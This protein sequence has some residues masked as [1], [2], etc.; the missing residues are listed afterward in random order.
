MVSVETCPE[1]GCLMPWHWR[2]TAH[3]HRTLPLFT[4]L[5]HWIKSARTWRDV[6]SVAVKFPEWFYCKQTCI[7]TAYWQGVTFEVLPLSSY[8]LSPTML[9][10]LETFLEF[11]LWNSFQYCH[12]ILGGGGIWASW[13][14]CSFKAEFIFGNSQKSFR[15]KSGEYGGCTIS[16]IDFG[17]KLLYRERLVSW[18]NIMMANPVADPKLRRFS[19]QSLMQ[20]LQCF[21]I[22][23]WLTIRMHQILHIFIGSVRSWTIT[24]FIIIDVLPTHFKPFMILRNIWLFHS[25][26]AI[27]PG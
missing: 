1:A 3:V 20:P 26:S 16:V 24:S 2:T 7:L 15:T 12:H 5:W 9:S 21:H 6:C 8:A 14:I 22:I 11:L 17:Q 19:I 4:F 27:S 23:T 13:N 18:T 10:L 25:F